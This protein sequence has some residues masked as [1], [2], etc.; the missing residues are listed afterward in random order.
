MHTDRLVV[1]ELNSDV[2]GRP[3]IPGLCIL[4]SIYNS[5]ILELLLGHK[6]LKTQMMWI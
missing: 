3:G 5:G 4:G 6:R 1:C 2:M